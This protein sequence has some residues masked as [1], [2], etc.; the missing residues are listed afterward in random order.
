MG[1]VPKRVS[2]PGILRLIRGFLVATRVLT[3]IVSH[4][5]EKDKEAGGGEPADRPNSESFHYRTFPRT[6]RLPFPAKP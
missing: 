4:P 3:S 5:E 6:V 1:L 2:D